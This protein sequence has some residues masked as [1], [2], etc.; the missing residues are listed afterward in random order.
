MS[1]A[2]SA[3]QSAQLPG[4]HISRRRHWFVCALAFTVVRLPR[5]VDRCRWA[6]GYGSCRI[7]T[8]LRWGAGDPNSGANPAGL[9]A[10]IWLGAQREGFLT[11]AR[12][13]TPQ[14]SRVVARIVSFACC[15]PSSP[16]VWREARK[17]EVSVSLPHDHICLLLLVG[18]SP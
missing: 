12:Q 2:D 9:P 13:L 10:A 6:Q 4:E 7:P 17:E 11:P 1:W 15:Y 18:N 14:A 3:R 5:T 8:L 16:R